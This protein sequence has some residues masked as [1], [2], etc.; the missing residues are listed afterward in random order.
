LE[1]SLAWQAS[2]TDES[3]VEGDM[4]TFFVGSL[5]SGIAEVDGCCELPAELLEPLGPEGVAI[6]GNGDAVALVGNGAQ[7]GLYAVY[8]FLERRLGCR[9][10]EPGR[11]YVPRLDSL[12][13]A[14]SHTHNP[15]FAYRGVAL[16]GPCT[17]EHYLNIIDWLAKNRA[18]SL[19][20]SC[21][22]YDEV[23]PRLIE[24]ILDRGLPMKIGAHSRKYFFP[25][26]KYF[27][28]HPEYF[29]L[30]KGKRTGDTQICYSNAES[31]DEYAANINRYLST[32]P[33]IAV[34]GLWPSDG[35]GFCECDQC[36]S[37]PTTDVLLDYTNALAERIHRQCPDVQVEFLSYIHY[38]TPPTASTPL[39]QVIPIY[40]EYWSRNQF[41]PITADLEENARCRAQLAQWAKLSP[42]MAVYGYYADDTMKR[43]LYNPVPDVVLADLEYYRSI[44]VDG[45]SVLMM[46]PQSW[47]SNGPHMYAYV[48]G[49]WD[50]ASTLAET[51]GDYF[52]SL[53]ADA[54]DAM[55]AHQ[56]AAR[57]L[58]ET[59]F[60]HGETGE[61]MLFNFHIKRFDPAR[62]ASSKNEFAGAVTQMRN[63]LADARRTSSDPWVHARIEVLDQDAQLIEVIYNVLS[64]A[65]GF[66][67]DHEESRKAR[68]HELM[69]RFHEN[70]VVE[71]DDFRCKILKSLM[72]QVVAVLGAE[73]AAQFDRVPVVPV[74]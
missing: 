18:N 32:R 50:G 13:L 3:A 16:H 71:E 22:V 4:P 64:E 5:D 6:L 46:C 65:A 33:E 37:K 67:L 12:D 47:W 7:G 66:K 9:W 62:E 53:Y 56:E 35:Y 73:E 68:V 72:P 2:I 34:I 69:G 20:F 1:R 38:T 10:P 14:V 30:V 57:A 54:A 61:E 60:G 59:K 58:F 29:A 19:Q 45:S 11:E 74:E 44:G 28:D 36:K 51:S 8:E 42:Q 17:D 23:R 63:E 27:S 15:A 31:A 26:A 24:A 39:P 41:H 55:A 25:S 49:S 43:F 48:K 52:R 21:E 40:C 70:Q